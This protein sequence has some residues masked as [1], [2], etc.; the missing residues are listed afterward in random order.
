MKEIKRRFG[1]HFDFHAAKDSTIGTTTNIED[2]E[3]YI[4]DAKPDFIQC[5]CKGHPGISS[6]P[7]RV[8]NRAAKYDKD[9]L[10]IWCEAAKKHGIP[11]FMHYSGAIDNEY[12]KQHPEQAEL[13]LNKTPFDQDTTCLFGSY[14]HDLLIPQLKE[15]ITDYG[16]DGVWVDGE[17]WG[18]HMDASQQA[19]V[20]LDTAETED[21]KKK[22]IRDAF[23][24]YVKTYVDELHEF[25]PDF[26]IMSNWLYSSYIPEKPE[27]NV[28]YLSGDFV[29]N[30]SAF[31]ARFEA[32]CLAVQGKP[33]DLMAWS[34]AHLPYAEKPAIQLCQEAAVVLTLGGGFQVYITQNKDGSA[35]KYENGRFAELSKFVREREMLYGKR[36]L[37]QVGVFYSADSYYKKADI[38]NSRGHHDQ[39][40][41]TINA[42][43]DAQYTAGIVY[44]YQ[45]DSLDRYDA[46]V[47]PQWEYISDENKSKL[48][49]YARTGGKLIVAGA[50]CCRQ[51]G[52]EI[53]L[54]FEL[55]ND[56]KRVYI[57]DENG[58]FALCNNS[59][60]ADRP[61]FEAPVCD[62]RK[63]NG[64]IYSDRDPDFGILPSYRTE[65]VGDGFVT[66]I[67]FSFGDDYFNAG[68]FVFTDYLKDIMNTL[69][70]PYIEVN[71]KLIDVTMQDSDDGIYVNLVNM[72]QGRHS[73][74]YPV[75]D[76][77]D[78]IYD[79]EITVNEEFES[80]S[81][82]LGEEFTAKT[83]NGKT[84]IS[85][86]R[87]DVHSIIKLA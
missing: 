60:E 25:K 79:I 18:I 36:P 81:M 71:R 7:T 51:F 22:I 55:K 5:D 11:I 13:Y 58:L 78:P 47:I 6:Y 8:G 14:V 59:V 9:N 39:I 10:K 1:L 65:K 70:K 35:R 46:V 82:P 77:I 38:F 32:R 20:Y 44:E 52:K 48:V 37:A 34:F 40:E 42:L 19:K 85:V 15:L 87:L 16:I 41:G 67:P 64:F 23:F 56:C 61:E 26:K 54:D 29:P 3:R 84:Y 57:K 24:R 4:L 12:V 75:Y 80:V 43:L 83:E 2:I 74:K 31:A 63:G 33:W 30:D 73:L 69:I 17:V 53:G 45:L 68:S 66:F 72:K 28:D 62:L 21:E 49:N 76:E 27:I 50:E 86:K